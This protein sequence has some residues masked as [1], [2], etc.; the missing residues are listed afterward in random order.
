MDEKLQSILRRMRN[1]I[2]EELD[3]EECFAKEPSIGEIGCFHCVLNKL[4]DDIIAYEDAVRL[5]WRE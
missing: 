5:A 3:G 4:F 1:V 2:N